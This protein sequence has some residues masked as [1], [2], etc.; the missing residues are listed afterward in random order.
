MTGFDMND[1]VSVPGCGKNYSITASKLAQFM[2][3][4][5][6]SSL[7]AI[8]LPEGVA[9]YLYPLKNAWRCA[10]TPIYFHGVLLNYAQRK[11]LQ[12]LWFIEVFK[13]TT[14]S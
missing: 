3:L 2:L 6:K 1:R 4:I 10:S 11:M 8:R 9:Y 12:S 7:P 13:A 14:R 5:I